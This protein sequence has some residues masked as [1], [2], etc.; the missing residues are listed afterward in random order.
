MNK[1]ISQDS[2]A[3]TFGC[4]SE[5]IRNWR[6]KDLQHKRRADWLR[7]GAIFHRVGIQADE[8]LFLPDENEKLKAENLALRSK[9]NDI[10]YE[11]NSIA[12]KFEG[13]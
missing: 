2:I 8:V 10:E 13:K 4:T 11:L 12:D 7:V 9:I 6:N 5:T 3:T 1:E